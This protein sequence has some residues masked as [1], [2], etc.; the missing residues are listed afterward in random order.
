MTESD[1]MRLMMIFNTVMIGIM[2]FQLDKVWKVVK[3]FV[4]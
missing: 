3:H 1:I 4:F 2:S